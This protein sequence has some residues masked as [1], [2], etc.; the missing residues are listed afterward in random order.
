L[1]LVLRSG[2]GDRRAL[3]RE[4]CGPDGGVVRTPGVLRRD[5]AGTGAVCSP[6]HRG[7]LVFGR[8]AEESPVLAGGPG[9]VAFRRGLDG[10]AQPGGDA[11]GGRGLPAALSL[12][13]ET[14]AAGRWTGGPGAGGRPA[15][16][17]GAQCGAGSGIHG[18]LQLGRDQL[19]YREQPASHGK[20]PSPPG[21]PAGGG[22]ALGLPVQHPGHRRAGRR[23]GIETLG[24]F[25]LL[26]PAGLEFLGGAAGCRA[27][28][29]R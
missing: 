17:L 26:V 27:A 20:I 18:G 4:D 14:A 3:D 22:I 11:S 25:V 7:D 8:G 21:H 19:L 23:P 16:R 29:R 9:R 6:G 13:M 28:A 5:A 10:P 1:P 15:A 2:P 12:A 24:G